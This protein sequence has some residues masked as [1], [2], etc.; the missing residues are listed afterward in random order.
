MA[1]NE[2]KLNNLCI[3]LVVSLLRKQALSLHYFRK[4]ALSLHYFILGKL[5]LIFSNSC[6]IPKRSKPS[7]ASFT[8]S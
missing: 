6:F 5:R 8:H 2:W 4:Q 7:V 3:L 1:Y